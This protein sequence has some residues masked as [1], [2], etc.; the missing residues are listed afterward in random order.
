M[1][2]PP[3]AHYS[4]INV[5]NISDEV[6][7]KVMGINGAYFKAFTE[8]FGLY[9][10]WWNKDLKVIEFWGPMHVMLDSRK[11]MNNRIK[12]INDN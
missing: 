5:S 9:Y 12:S 2:N 3:I 4:H 7:N 1:Y 11:V 6:L 10:V 8:I